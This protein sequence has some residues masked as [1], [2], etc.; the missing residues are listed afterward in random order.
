MK[1]V[2]IFF[3]VIISYN[4]FCID[5]PLIKLGS[6]S[7]GN[8]YYSRDKD[9]FYP[10]EISDNFY[11]YLQEKF[12]FY[13][14]LKYKFDFFYIDKNKYSKNLTD[15][16]ILKINNY[17]I[18]DINI[19]KNNS[20]YLS[21][22]PI[23]EKDDNEVLFKNRN[24]LSYSLKFKNFNFKLSYSNNYLLKKNEK[25]N[26]NLSFLF[27]FNF[28]KVDFI[29]Y[30]CELVC[31]FQHYIYKDLFITPFNKAI[32]SFEVAIDFNKIDFENLF[33]NK[34]EEADFNEQY[35]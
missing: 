15:L 3:I 30:K 19:N 32:F 22:V 6:K 18:F 7:L 9:L 34:N 29:K 12:N 5:R 33:N 10:Y 31:Y 4:F 27:Y 25:F 28:P 20:F 2:S 13:F 8:F 14:T 24:K 11:F 1:K 17:F 35:Y 21:V 16:V 26:H 23:I